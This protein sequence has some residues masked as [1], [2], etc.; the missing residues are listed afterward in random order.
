MANT[1]QTRKTP[2]QTKSPT[3]EQS[4]SAQKQQSL[5]GFSALSQQWDKR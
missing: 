4:R 1:K 3:G 5:S 2:S